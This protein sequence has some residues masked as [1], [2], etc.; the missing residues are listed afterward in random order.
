[1]RWWILA[2]ISGHLL[3]GAA[4]L[5]DKILLSSSFKRSGTYAAL[6][7][8]LS[9]FVLPVLPWIDLPNGFVWLPIALFGSLFV[10][11]IWLFFEALQEGEASR[12]VPI[13]GVLIPIFTLL[14]SNVFIGERLPWE[15]IWGFG[16]LIVATLILTAVGKKGWLPLRVILICTAS[17]FLFAAS[18]VAGKAAYL[19]EGFV[20]VF[21]SSRIF[22]AITAIAI[23]MFATG[24][25]S[26]LS[27]LLPHRRDSKTLKAEHRHSVYLML[28]GQISGAFGFLLVQYAISLGS[29]SLVN[30]LQAVQYAFLVLAA[31]V[32]GPKLASMLK[33]DRHTRVILIKTIAIAFVGIGL[34][35]IAV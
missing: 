8:G 2:A 9:C 7:G 28:T 32:G 14:E 35:L 1:M 29:A 6:I 10:I 13:V 18:S 20:S 31:W 26:E 27:K 5:I 19:Q 12:I 34:Y 4:F 16:L 3:N 25:K 23:G 17:A 30:A 33:E 24:V 21:V 15:N 11:A 22:A